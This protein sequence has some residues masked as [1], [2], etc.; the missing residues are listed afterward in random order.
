MSYSWYLLATNMLLAGADKME[1]AF[2]N[3]QQ[4]HS[5]AY[6]YKHA[7]GACQSIWFKDKLLHYAE[8]RMRAQGCMRADAGQR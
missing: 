6:K 4:E 5:D 2:T 8:E 7:I 1:N 3:V